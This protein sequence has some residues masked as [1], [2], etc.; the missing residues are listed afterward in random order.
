[1][2]A[3]RHDIIIAASATD[4]ITCTP[5][6]TA[7]IDGISEDA[8]PVAAPFAGWN[9]LFLDNTQTDITASFAESG[10]PGD[11]F[12]GLAPDTYFVQAQNISTECFSDPFQVNV[13]DVSQDPLISM[14]MDNP[15]YACSGTNFTGILNPTIS[16]GSDG[17]LTPANYTIVW[18]S[19]ATGLPTAFDATNRATDLEVGDYR[20]VVTDNVGLDAGCITTQDF[21]VT[22]A[23]HDIIIAASAT[24]QITCTPDGTA[25]IDGISEDAA[26]VAAP[27]AGWNILFLDN[28]QTDITASFAES[29]VPGDAFS[30]LAPDTYFVQ[31]QNISTE[32]F[33][34]PFQVIVNDVSQD[35]LVDIDLIT[36]Q[37]S[38]NP[39]PVS[40][41]G[42]LN[43]IS[44]EAGSGV[45]DPLGYI[46]SWHKGLDTS[47]PSIG[48]L[49][50]IVSLGIG[51]YTVVARSISS[52]CESSYSSYMPYEYLEPTFNTYAG[53]KTVCAPDNGSIEVTDISLDGNADLLSDYTFNWHH[54]VYSTGDTPDAIIPGNDTQTIYMN[55]K[56]G[57]YYTIAFENWL[58]VESLPVKIEV[59]D[60][61]TNPIIVFDATNYQPLTSCDEATFADGQLAVNVYED[62]SN[63]YLAPPPYNYSYAWY[64]GTVVNPATIISGET[65][66]TISGLTTGNYTVV[67][68]NLG[69]N[70][71][72]ESTFTIEDESTTPIVIASQMANINC[73]A[74]LANGIASANVINS[75]NGFDFH[76]YEGTDTNG[77]ADYQGTVWYDLLEGSYTVIAVDQ[78]FGTCQ[79]DPVTIEVEEA[80]VHPIILVNEISPVTNCDPERPNG[81][82]SAVTQDGIN[83]HTFSWYLNDVLYAT[84]PIASTLGIMEYQLIA[85]ND[86]TQCET[87]MTVKPSQL[88]S[89]VP[90]PEVEILN[91]LTSC[92]EPNGI[93]T[94]SIGG[95]VTDHMFKY[96][97]L[98]S[99]EEA[100][101]YYD[102][103]KLYDL[104]TSKYY[105]IAE[106]R[107]TGCLSDSTEFAISNET[108]FPEIEI[109][110]EASSCEEA[111][112]TAD[113]VLS[114]MTKDFKVYWH[115][116]NGFE[117]QQKEIV[118]IPIGA[119]TVEVEGS[120]GCITTMTTEV[121]GDVKIFN[122]VT[123]NNDGMNDYFKI[124]CLE[125]FPDN[126]VKIYNRAGRLVYEQ[127][128]YDIHSEKRF[129]GI[130][131][132]GVSVSGTE[133]P[134]GTYFY[135]VDK[136]DGS[137]A[138]VGYLEL[139]R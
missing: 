24:D 129:E 35:P 6:G 126:V 12:S 108:Y 52:N 107:K 138:D 42:Q 75:E 96:Y 58:M 34:D 20:I 59:T 90:S 17:D 18:T 21:T 50:S 77:N 83:G 130:S 14:V 103:Y 54:D 134:I 29:G 61:T 47:S 4:Q 44:V 88:L 2:T 124:V 89:T 85:T 46:Y 118:Y 28:T 115:N 39:N 67:A 86:A 104:D 113:V 112:G 53:P 64:N 81:I 41:T 131:N 13:N 123:P 5:D 33:S 94:A 68:I 57:S 48:T 38:L 122:G 91:D 74:E 136:N 65:I 22:A 80:K 55:L 40:W 71:Q 121:K 128:A 120:D 79:S 36:P 30:G 60:S 27:F 16:G 56:D 62:N 105:A 3:A 66:N 76:W 10:V 8:A 63:P 92:N 70:C 114:D 99:G 82:L 97:Y 125:H 11:A 31:A 72:S 95:S 110:T 51:N 111:T 32:C 1:V 93:V 109:I 139:K 102:D 7:Q 101:N 69:N 19:V 117:A 106:D 116:E 87:S 133:L 23:R 137:K 132:K 49:D 119:Y 135:V 127:N 78:Q 26:P 43:A 25:Q 37:Y 84:G 9:I 45:A 73:P 98:N 15:D 100:T